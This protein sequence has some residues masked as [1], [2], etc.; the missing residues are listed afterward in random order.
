MRKFL[1]QKITMPVWLIATLVFVIIGIVGSVESN[2]NTGNTSGQTN[3]NT[4]NQTQK[5]Q[6]TT[7]P[8]S[9]ATATHPPAPTATATHTPVWTVVQT[10]TGNGDEKTS[11]FNTPDSWRIVWSCDPSSSFGGQYNLMADVDNPDTT[12]LDFGAINTIC[13]SSNTT[14]TTNEYQGGRVYLDVTSEGSWTIQVEV[15]K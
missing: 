14:G 12:P 7:S 9:T 2:A 3:A 8:N 13:Q 10:F 4:T 6:K 5:S 1:V 11:L 15:L